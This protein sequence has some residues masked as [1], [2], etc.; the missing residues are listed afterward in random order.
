MGRAA[1]AP[2][3]LGEGPSCLFRLRVAPGVPGLVAATRHLCL[4]L[5]SWSLGPLLFLPGH[6]PVIGFKAHPGSR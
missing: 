2:K 1:L 3:A 6:P 5:L 4:Q